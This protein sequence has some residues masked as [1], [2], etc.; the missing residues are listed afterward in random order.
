MQVVQALHDGDNVRRLEFC[1]AELLR[2]KSNPGH[3]QFLLFSDEANFHLD[4]RVNRQNSRIWARDN[5]HAVDER[6]LHSPKV[7]VWSGIWREGIV[8][9]FFFDGTVNANAYLDMLKTEMLPELERY[10]M[11]KENCIF[12]QDG[13][14]PHYAKSVRAWLNNTFPRRW[15]GRGSDY[16]DWPPRSPDLNMCDFFVWGFIKGLVYK[17]RIPSTEELKEKIE[18]AFLEIDD[19]MRERAFLAYEARLRLCVSVN[20]GHIES[21]EP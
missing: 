5:P 4:G 11:T 9:P 1:K 6:H 18:G 13:A 12:M 3:L 8:G 10:H 17:K 19:G 7:T 15:M 14:A 2:I 16:M 21:A 20:G